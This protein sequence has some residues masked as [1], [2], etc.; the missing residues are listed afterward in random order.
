MAKYFNTLL[1]PVTTSQQ[2][3]QQEPT[4]PIQASKGKS[5][6]TAIAVGVVFGIGGPL[7]IVGII[8]CVLLYIKRKNEKESLAFQ[9]NSIRAAETGG[10]ENPPVEMKDVTK[11]N[12]TPVAA[13]PEFI[14]PSAVQ[15]K[16]QKEAFEIDYTELE[17]KELIGKG[18]FGAVYRVKFFYLFKSQ[19]FFC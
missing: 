7:L 4:T 3:T 11:V 17:I 8:I 6:A 13:Q 15:P 12:P 18:A 14:D 19:H 2:T 5:N 9:R 1:R 16:K 10:N